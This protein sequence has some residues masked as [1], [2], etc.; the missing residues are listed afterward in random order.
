M[1]HYPS[2]PGVLAWFAKM[3][4]ELDVREGK[5]LYELRSDSPKPF[6]AAEVPVKDELD[7]AEYFLSSRV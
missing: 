2:G 6:H 1:N 4:P 7:E 3:Y 5:E